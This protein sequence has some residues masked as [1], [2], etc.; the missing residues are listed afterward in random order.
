MLQYFFPEGPK[1]SEISHSR[2]MIIDYEYYLR[3]RYYI[4]I[5]NVQYKNITRIV[6]LL[7]IV[8]HKYI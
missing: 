5:I 3:C 7:A 4:T 8:G 6:V 1:K 2:F